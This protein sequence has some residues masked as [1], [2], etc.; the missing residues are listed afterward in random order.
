[1]HYTVGKLAKAAQ[2]EAILICTL[3]FHISRK[4][5]PNFLSFAPEGDDFILGQHCIDILSLLAALEF[6][7]RVNDAVRVHSKS[8]PWWM[9]L[10]P[11]LND[12][13]WSLFSNHVGKG[14]IAARYQA[15]AQ[16]LMDWVVLSMI[17]TKVMLTHL[18]FNIQWIV[19][20]REPCMKW[21][22]CRQVA[23]FLHGNQ[24]NVLLQMVIITTY[25]HT[26]VCKAPYRRSFCL[27]FSAY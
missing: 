17:T 21:W 20:S 22:S 15:S 9:E 26:K 12:S 10:Q 16:V 1:M 6:C 11:L 18:A 5:M 19:G 23:S 24:S 14:N 3:L 27:R 25:K 13:I 7:S 2:V 8:D 4:P